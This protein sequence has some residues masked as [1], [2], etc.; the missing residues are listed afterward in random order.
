[1][2]TKLEVWLRLLTIARLLWP[3][4]KESFLKLVDL[5]VT[6]LIDAPSL[7]DEQ[8]KKVREFLEA[9]GPL[10][11]LVNELTTSNGR[12]NIP[13][14]SHGSYTKSKRS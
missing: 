13:N 14:R 5:L 7:S 4:S 11:G 1:M 9:L 12:V 8:G 6:S 10:K 3:T 2:N